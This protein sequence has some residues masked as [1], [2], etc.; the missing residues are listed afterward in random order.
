MRYGGGSTAAEGKKYDVKVTVGAN[1]DI[2]STNIM[3]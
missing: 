3:I 1:R 2:V